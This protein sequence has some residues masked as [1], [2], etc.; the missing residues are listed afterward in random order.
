MDATTKTT[1][2][3]SWRM[4]ILSNM[5]KDEWNAR[6]LGLFIL[7]RSGWA[8]RRIQKCSGCIE[9]CGAKKFLLQSA[10]MPT[11]KELQRLAM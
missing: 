9:S 1:N 8:V 6:Y 4:N 2:P 11:E 10:A 5:H 3:E 7:H